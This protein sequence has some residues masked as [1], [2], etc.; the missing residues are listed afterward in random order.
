MDDAI[1]QHKEERSDDII[2]TKPD[3]N[4]PFSSKNMA[5]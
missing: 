1:K 3:Q 2:K 4:Q 5:L